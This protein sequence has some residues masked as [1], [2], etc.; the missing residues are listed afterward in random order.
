MMRV[1]VLAHRQEL[2]CQAE[3]KFDLMWPG[4]SVS[5]VKGARKELWEQVSGRGG[6]CEVPVCAFCHQL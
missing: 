6:G 3:E 1:L 2:L 5:W 4:V